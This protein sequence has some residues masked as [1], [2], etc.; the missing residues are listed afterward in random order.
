MGLV[1]GLIFVYWLECISVL[2]VKVL[3]FNVVVSLVL[4]VSVI[5]CLVLKVLK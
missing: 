1:V 4:L 3:M 2:L 5:F